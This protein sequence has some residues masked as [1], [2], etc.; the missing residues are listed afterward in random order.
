VGVQQVGQH[1]QDGPPPVRTERRP[2]GLGATGRRDRGV[3]VVGTGQADLGLDLA[4]RRIPVLVHA[5]GTRS[6]PPV[7]DQ[8]ALGRQPPHGGR[9][10]RRPHGTT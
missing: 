1:Q 5:G 6:H 3:D 4:R 8:V 9:D 7:P 2:A 10:R